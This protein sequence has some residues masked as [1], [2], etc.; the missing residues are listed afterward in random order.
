MSKQ[1]KRK[2]PTKDELVDKLMD[3][4]EGYDGSD[5]SAVRPT[6]AIRAIEVIN[7]M[8]GYNEAE[9]IEQKIEEITFE[10]G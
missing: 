6:D 8:L 7:R 10:I 2:N 9:K 3:I 4:V 1:T 5:E